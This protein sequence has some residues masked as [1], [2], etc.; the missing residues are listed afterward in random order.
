MLMYKIDCTGK[1]V[2]AGK[3]IQKLVCGP[4][5]LIKEDYRSKGRHMC[6]SSVSNRFSNIKSLM[7]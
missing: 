6:L 7:L 3:L 4:G 1:R 2:K 5:L